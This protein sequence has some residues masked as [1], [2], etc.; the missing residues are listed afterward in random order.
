[1]DFPPVREELRGLVWGLTR[2]DEREVNAEEL[3]R[4]QTRSSTPAAAPYAAAPRAHGAPANARTRSRRAA[5][6]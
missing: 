1:M 3:L 4:Q 2:K 6:A 5:S